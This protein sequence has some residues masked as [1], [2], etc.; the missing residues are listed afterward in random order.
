MYVAPSGITP[1]LEFSLVTFGVPVAIGPALQTPV[2]VLK[3]SRVPITLLG[4]F[5]PNSDDFDCHHSDHMT[6]TLHHNS[7]NRSANP[8]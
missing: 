8:L 5:C 4:Q 7:P 6:G 1:V 2:Q 3:R